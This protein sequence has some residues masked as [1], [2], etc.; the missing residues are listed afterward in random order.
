MYANEHDRKT[1]IMVGAVDAAAFAAPILTMMFW[2]EASPF[3]GN[4]GIDRGI[5]AALVLVMAHLF[6]YWVRKAL[7]FKD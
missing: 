7:Y 4:V 6:A 3:T 5:G 1:R 2:T